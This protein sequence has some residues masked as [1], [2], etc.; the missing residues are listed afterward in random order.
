[1]TIQEA[2]QG[3][4]LSDYVH[5]VV[6]SPDN[7]PMGGGYA[8]DVIRRYGSL[9]ITRTYITRDGGMRITTN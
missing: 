7:Y 8:S 1:M 5:I 4:R 3:L 9:E 2:I 6:C